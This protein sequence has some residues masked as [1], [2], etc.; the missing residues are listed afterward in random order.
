MRNYTAIIAED[1]FEVLKTLPSFSTKLYIFLISNF[2]T[3]DETYLPITLTNSQI[4]KVFNKRPETISRYLSQLNKNNLI[5]ISYIPT[6]NGIQ[7]FI[8][9]R[10][11]WIK[12][13]SYYIV[14]C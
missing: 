1:D 3:N 13:L 6:R 9:R 14:E 8:D 4:G 12:V 2:S 5:K 7:R 11:I 10:D